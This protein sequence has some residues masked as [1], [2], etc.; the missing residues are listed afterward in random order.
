MK[1]PRVLVLR[2]EGQSDDLAR[3]LLEGGADPVIVPAIRILPLSNSAQLDDVLGRVGDFDW[4]VVTSVSGVA[5]LF[6]RMREREVGVD[7]LPGRIAAV[8][9]ATKQALQDR[10][11][12]EVWLPR[13]FTTAAVAEELPDPASSVLLLRAEIADSR[14]EELLAER[15]FEVERVD[16]YITEP[17]GTRAIADA[18]EAGVDAIAFSSA[19]IVDAFVV[20]AGSDTKGAAVCCIG[21]ATA[22][23]CGRVG[24]EVDVEAPVHTVAALAEAIIG[25]MKSEEVLKR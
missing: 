17:T 23:A 18:L 7:D 20:A 6:E 2:P 15:G 22:E 1:R 5:A 8:G 13:S 4:L 25:F 9:P 12:R 19:S 11:V 21:P 14:L 10:G 3:T 24:M 16:A